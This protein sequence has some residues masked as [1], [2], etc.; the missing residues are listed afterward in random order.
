[1]QSGLGPEH[2]RIDIQAFLD[3]L[4][5]LKKLE[6]RELLSR[7]SHP[8]TPIRARALQLLQA[9]GGAT[10]SAEAMARVDAEVAELSKLM[11]FE[12]THPLDVHARDFVLAGGLLAAS[13]DGE[14]SE[15][16]RELLIDILLPIC[17]DPEAAAA[18]IKS[19]DEA[20]EILGKNAEWLRGNA[21]QERFGIFRQLVHIVAV[22][23]HIDD[24]EK[25]FVLGAAEMLDIPP[26]AATE[27]MFDVLAGY[28]QSKAVRKAPTQGFGF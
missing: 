21:G 2:L 26:K 15:E 17:A 20:R 1:M 16:E 27:M 5:D 6:R 23:G 7:F 10:A 25:E 4:S 24:K 8:V 11:D 9:A 14:F 28:L 18:G 12:V 3:Q 19:A 13:A 22:D